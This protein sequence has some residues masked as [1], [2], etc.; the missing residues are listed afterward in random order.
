MS[1]Y[2]HQ[3]CGYQYNSASTERNIPCTLYNAKRA[4]SHLNTS[5]VVLKELHFNQFSLDGGSKQREKDA[6]AHLSA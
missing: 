3:L 1:H 4:V 5:E 2:R 6:F